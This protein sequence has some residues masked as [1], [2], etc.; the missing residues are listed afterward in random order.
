MLIG[1]SDNID[2]GFDVG[3]LWSS[4]STAGK[5]LISKEIPAAVQAAVTKQASAVATPLAQQAAQ[6]KAQQAYSKGS[7]A[8]FAVGGLALGAI[9][10]GGGWQRRAIGGAVLGSVGAFVG[11]KFGLQLA[12]AYT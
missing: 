12:S 4:I 8:L 2:L 7:V 9:L 11:F 3:S 1:D 10:A 6:Q 5:D